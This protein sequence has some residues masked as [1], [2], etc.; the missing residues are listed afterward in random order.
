[1]SAGFGC[2]LSRLSVA[3]LGKVRGHVGKFS[4]SMFGRKKHVASMLD[5]RGM[6]RQA[7]RQEILS[8]VQ[9]IESGN[10]SDGVDGSGGGLVR[11]TRDRAVFAEVQVTS[12]VRCLNLGL[13]RIASFFGGMRP[14][15][16]KDRSATKESPDDGL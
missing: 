4:P 12:E 16:R 9:D 5:L 11:L 15:H 2:S 3:L 13:G 1:M 10:S 14:R 8:V 7:E 6:R